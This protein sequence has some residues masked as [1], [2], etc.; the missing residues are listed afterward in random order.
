MYAARN[1]EVAVRQLENPLCSLKALDVTVQLLR[2]PWA[3]HQ[4]ALP[5]TL[6]TMHVLVYFE[7]ILGLSRRETGSQLGPTCPK[8]C[9]TSH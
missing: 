7:G 2:V 4:S 8:A 6:H 5:R 3:V 9:W 1:D